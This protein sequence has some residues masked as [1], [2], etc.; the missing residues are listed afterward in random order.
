MY[1]FI[2]VEPLRPVDRRRVADGGHALAIGDGARIEGGDGQLG[3]LHLDQRQIVAGRI[4]DQLAAIAA[5]ALRGHYTDHEVFL[6]AHQLNH[7]RVGQ[8]LVW[9][10][11][12]A[13]AVPHEIGLIAV[14]GDEHDPHHAAH[15]GGD[16]L[17]FRLGR[18]E[19]REEKRANGEQA[20]HIHHWRDM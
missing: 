10:D 4:G 20:K 14:G 5:L 13:R 7:M 16:I 9:G 6:A 12:E 2:E 15:R 11:R 8:Y 18:E 17:L 1:H 3:V 19:W